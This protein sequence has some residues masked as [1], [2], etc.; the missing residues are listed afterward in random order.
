MSSEMFPFASHPDYHLQYDLEQFRTLLQ[1]L[2]CLAKK[3]KQRLTFHPGQYNQLTSQKHSVVQNTIVDLN[4]HAK[5]MDMMGLDSESVIV[6]HG[7]AK[8]KSKI[9]SLKLFSNNF[10]LLSPSAQKRLVLE[11]CELAYSIEDLLPVCQKHQ[12]PLVV[13]FHHHNINPGVKHIDQLLTLAIDTWKVRNITPLFHLSESKP[14]VSI[15]DSI[16]KR[17]AHSDYVQELPHSLLEL[18]KTQII[19][20]DVEAK[21][22]ELAVQHLFKRYWTTNC[23]YQ[24]LNVTFIPLLCLRSFYAYVCNVFKTH[25]QFIK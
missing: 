9:E 13:D 10:T 17:R 16:T 18:I 3:Y 12:I 6:I 2:G 1:K 4:L 8:H 11:N 5:L 22:K 7:G 23:Q 20:L 24:N 15:N 21:H 25:K 14:D 19:H